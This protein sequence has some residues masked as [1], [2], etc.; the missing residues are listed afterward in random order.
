MVCKKKI[1]QFQNLIFKIIYLK[2]YVCILLLPKQFFLFYFLLLLYLDMY[3]LC[4]YSYNHFCSLNLCY[5]NVLIFT[6]IEVFILNRLNINFLKT[7]LGIYCLHMF[8]AYEC[9][10]VRYEFYVFISLFHG[11]IAHHPLFHFILNIPV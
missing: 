3:S 7:I 10:H 6:I 11:H 4:L 2:M 8:Q 1:F 9:L 5:Y